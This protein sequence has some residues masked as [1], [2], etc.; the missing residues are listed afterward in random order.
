MSA[1]SRTADLFAPLP[2]HFH[3]MCPFQSLFSS[4]SLSQRA[5]RCTY[6][7]PKK[8]HGTSLRRSRLPLH[9]IPHHRL[10]PPARLVVVLEIDVLGRHEP[11]TCVDG[12]ASR[13]RFRE[14]ANAHLIG[15][16]AAVVDEHGGDAA[17]LVG[18][19]AEADVEYWLSGRRRQPDTA[20]RF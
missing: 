2:S 3:L 6:S 9:M 14:C 16:L 19:V 18:W 7:I 11:L 17:A 10:F 15:S 12:L 8:S 1:A 5:R 4:V 20:S 13:T